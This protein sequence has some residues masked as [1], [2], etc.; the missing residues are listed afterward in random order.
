MVTE[1]GREGELVL[2]QAREGTR[3]PPSCAEERAD[4]HTNPSSGDGAQLGRSWR[5]GSM[6]LETVPECLG[7]MFNLSSFPVWAVLSS[8]SVTSLLGALALRRGTTHRH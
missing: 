6:G 5:G 1:E 3:E 2:V 8:S 7:E 4:S